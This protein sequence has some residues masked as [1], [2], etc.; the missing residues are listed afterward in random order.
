M[1]RIPTIPSQHSVLHGMEADDTR[2]ALSNHSE[3]VRGA[4][5]MDNEQILR[6]ALAF[7]LSQSA[8]CTAARAI[9]FKALKA[10]SDSD[11]AGGAN[12]LQE[13]DAWLQA[14]MDETMKRIVELMKADEERQK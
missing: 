3:L 1:A 5:T 4:Y 2:G 8:M 10:T 6:E 12:T 11:W 7:I 14:E 9:A 13:C